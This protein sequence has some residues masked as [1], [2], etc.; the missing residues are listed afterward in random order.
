MFN[1]ISLI[2]VSFLLI[3]VY[4]VKTQG[5][6]VENLSPSMTNA[7]K[8]ICAICILLGHITNPCFL[9]FHELSGPIV[10]CFFA[11][12]GYGLTQQYLIKGN[13]YIGKLPSKIVKLTLPYFACCVL[14]LCLE[15]IFIGKITFHEALIQIKH[16][17]FSYFLTFSWLVTAIIY[18]Y[19]NFYLSFKCKYKEIWIWLGFIFWYLYV[20][21]ILPGN[22]GFMWGSSAS[23]ALSVTYA[24]H[25]E[26]F[27]KYCIILIFLIVLFS[28]L[29][30]IKYTMSTLLVLTSLGGIISQS[31]ILKILGKISYEVYI[32]Q[33]VTLI[34]L[35]NNYYVVPHTYCWL[36]WLLV[37]LF[38]SY[39]FHSINK[40]YVYVSD[41]GVSLLK[42]DFY[43][44][45]KNNCAKNSIR[46]FLSYIW[47]Y[48]E[49]RQLVGYRLATTNILYRSFGWLMRKSSRSHNL[50]IVTHD[51][52]GGFRPFHAFSTIVF[53]NKIG[54]NFCVFQN[55]TIGFNN[56][57]NPI[58]GDNVTIY[59]GACV[60]GGISIGDN[61]VIGACSVV[62]KDIP[63]NTMVM[64]NPALPI[65]KYNVST[66][67]WE[68]IKDEKL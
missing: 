41:L 16:G 29:D 55:V 17:H 6:T 54:R 27:N 8:G 21:Y 5:K 53:A 56:G 23:F 4:F 33:G 37:T 3:L 26:R 11:M 9:F 52:G 66:K 58:I 13:E 32:L 47:H 46:T 62:S 67:K 61:V 22:N 18:F 30:S 51:I 65:K 42:E 15:H 1:N 10:G 20:N 2:V 68:K 49:F 40:R 45:T 63:S 25:K 36:V 59:A 31:K 34:L 39:I 38:A 60:Y 57:K 24:L 43:A 12:S 35:V 14:F 50:Y 64:G 44:W 28:P 7:I 48:S 19:V